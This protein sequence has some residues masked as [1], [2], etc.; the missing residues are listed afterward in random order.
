MEAGFVA[1]HPPGRVLSLV[2]GAFAERFAHIASMC[3]R[4]VDRYEVAW[5]QVHAIPQLE[6]RLSIRKYVAITT[7][8]SETSTGALND[9]ARVLGCAPHR[10]R[11][12]VLSTVSA[13]S[14]EPSC[15]LTS[16]SSTTY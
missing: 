10:F 13:D 3:G 11:F 9:I 2:N 4:D 1:L 8:H 15:D 12:S 7:V 5:G 6:E 14:P 16:G